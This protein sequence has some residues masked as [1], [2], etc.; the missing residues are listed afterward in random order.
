MRYRYGPPGPCCPAAEDGECDG[1]ICAQDAED[2][3]ESAAFDRYDDRR[4]DPDY[5]PRREP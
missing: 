2:A 4:N 5:R 1:V 3:A